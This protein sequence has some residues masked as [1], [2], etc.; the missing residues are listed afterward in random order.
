MIYVID[1]KCMSRLFTADMCGGGTLVF[2]DLWGFFLGRADPFICDEIHIN[3]I[4]AADFAEELQI[5]IHNIIGS[6][7]YLS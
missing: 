2:V 1:L 6:N 3:E 4:E 5:T 7:S